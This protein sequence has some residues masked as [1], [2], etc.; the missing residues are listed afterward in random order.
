MG[1]IQSP[2]NEISDLHVDLQ[3]SE[4]M[5]TNEQTPES[6]LSEVTQPTSSSYKHMKPICRSPIEVLKNVQVVPTRKR[7]RPS[8]KC[9]VLSFN[10]NGKKGKLA[11]ASSPIPFKSLSN[12]DKMQCKSNKIIL[13]AIRH[14]VNAFHLS[15]LF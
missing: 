10:N 4:D 6:N 8:K 13:V 5:V 1:I 12:D 2:T 14:A 11:K 15:V 9:S 7:G 3:I